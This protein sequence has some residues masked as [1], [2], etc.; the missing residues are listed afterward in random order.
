[1]RMEKP[2]AQTLA[3]RRKT[4]KRLRMLLEHMEQGRLAHGT[5][6]FDKFRSKCGTAG[7]MGGELPSLFPA[8]WMW[9]ANEP[10]CKPDITFVPSAM[11]FFGLGKGLIYRLFVPY[12]FRRIP[13]YGQL[14]ASA[15]REEVTANLARVIREL[16]RKWRL[17]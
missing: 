16:E 15:S 7:C 5:F 10:V 12:F 14:P 4:I 1:M 6:R 13:G 3:R 9:I 8:D 2:S 11:R 17:A